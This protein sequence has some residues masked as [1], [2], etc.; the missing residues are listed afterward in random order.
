M[1]VS[2]A[3]GVDKV[4]PRNDTVLD[5]ASLPVRQVGGSKQLRGWNQERVVKCFTP[6]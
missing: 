5:P 1:P 2:V 3:C 6:A 4:G